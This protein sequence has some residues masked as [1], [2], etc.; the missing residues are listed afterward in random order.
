MNEWKLIFQLANF[1]Y[2]CFGDV[3]LKTQKQNVLIWL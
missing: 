2:S 3:P 1:I